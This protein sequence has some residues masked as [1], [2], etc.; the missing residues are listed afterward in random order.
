MS[1]PQVAVARLDWQR[2]LQPWQRAS[3]FFA[4]V[5]AATEGETTASAADSTAVSTAVDPQQV[6]PDCLLI[7]TVMY[8]SC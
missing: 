1:L 7:I 5:S 8:Y 3:P 2:L 4:D 6:M